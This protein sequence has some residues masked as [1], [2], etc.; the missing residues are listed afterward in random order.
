[1]NEDDY[2][3]GLID[4]YNVVDDFLYM[5]VVVVVEYLM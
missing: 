3:I 2:L 1:M 4:S 5:I